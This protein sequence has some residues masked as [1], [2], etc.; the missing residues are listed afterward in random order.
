M[1]TKTKKLIII[2]GNALIHRSFHALPPTLKTK[3]G[4]LVNAVYG[5][6]SFLLKALLEFKP[7]YVVLT[8]DKKGPTFRHV[9]YADYKATRVKAP[10]ELY[11]QIP[12]VK[13]VATALS[14]PIFEMSGYEADDLIGTICAQIKTE[15]NLD[16]II[17]TG[18]M[19][20]L[21]LVNESTRVYTMSR[22]LSDTIIYNETKVKERYNLRP[23]QIIDYKALR[24]DPSDNIPGVRGIGEKTASELL[25]TFKNLDGLYQAVKNDNSKISPR[26]LD[27]LKTHKADA[28]LSRE[29]A[30]IHLGAPIKFKLQDISFS[31]FDLDKVI[32]LFSQLEFRSLL[33]KAKDLRD[34]IK[35]SASS[36]ADGPLSESGGKSPDRPAGRTG[37]KSKGDM[38]EPGKQNKQTATEIKNDLSA[39]K[40]ARNAKDFKY[41]KIDNKKD[42]QNFLKK[43]KTVAA[44]T[45]D[46]ETTSLDPLTTELL[47]LSFSWTKGEAYFVVT[48]PDQIN[49]AE[50][51][52]IAALK[53]SR[54]D[55]FNY[56]TKPDSP[57][58]KN[59]P[60]KNIHP[61]LKDL[62]PIF[63]DPK[64]KKHGHNLK[65]D[66]RVLTAQGLIVG[67]LGFDTM[68]AA[69]LLNP[70]NRQ[71]NLDALTFS[72]LGFEKISKGNLLGEGKNEI[73][74]AEIDLDKLS[75]YS[76]E[77]ADFTEQLV[78]ILEPK[79][80][81]Q[82]LTDLFNKIEMPLVEVLADMEN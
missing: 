12:L 54:P 17:I 49:S 5:F 44:F 29:L 38:V 20:T 73:S 45:F 79:L 39:Q 18:D 33:N 7:E 53:N 57:K 77:D 34:Q 1:A 66:T 23:D 19:D 61:W 22:G 36:R 47:G 4:L 69:Y 71:H 13:E 76:G 10:D 60:E 51:K 52:S 9:A 24:G 26:I 82:K 15:K 14:I 35:I 16:K 80:K 25:N 68:I 31:N 41:H 27:L 2:D 43:L 42:F 48:K 32:T 67:G 8:L 58:M 78:K 28:Y 62:A 74:W 81:A 30:T 75:S 65:F 6:T 40:F 21:Q 3:D 55:L 46:V 37:K 64:I 56:Q 59:I 11:E 70:D 72:E 50:S 63:A